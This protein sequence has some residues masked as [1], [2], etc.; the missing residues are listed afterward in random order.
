MLS[1][2]VGCGRSAD[3]GAIDV[4]RLNR[5]LAW[6]IHQQKLAQGFDVDV[7]VAC[8]GTD[9]LHFACD[10]H[11]TRPRGRD[12]HWTVQVA[13]GPPS[14]AQRCESDRGDALQ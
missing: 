6:V 8:A 10:V 3:A 14:N 5:E 7:S 9:G 4:P 13:C 11:A 2:A 1:V 12:N